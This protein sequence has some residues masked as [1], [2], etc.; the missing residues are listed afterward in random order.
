VKKVGDLMKELGFNPEADDG[1]K[2][3]F[4]KHLIKQANYKENGAE[5][6][7]IPQAVKAGSHIKEIHKNLDKTESKGQLSFQL[8]GK[9]LA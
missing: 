4:I 7:E 2:K 3:A 1:A 8:D 9:K 6:F 5:V